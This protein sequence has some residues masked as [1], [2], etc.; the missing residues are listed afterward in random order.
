MIRRGEVRAMVVREAHIDGYA[1]AIRISLTG[2]GEEARLGAAIAVQGLVGFA[3]SLKAEE[4]GMDAMLDM[5]ERLSKE[6][7]P[8]GGLPS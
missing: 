4:R 6:L 7:G 5:L 2:R 3:R 1:R 8:L